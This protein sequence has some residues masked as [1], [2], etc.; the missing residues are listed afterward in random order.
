MLMSNNRRSLQD[1]H[2]GLGIGNGMLSAFQPPQ[3]HQVQMPPPHP[4]QIYANV[5]QQQ[6]QMVLHAYHQM[7]TEYRKSMSDLNEFST[8]GI[9]KSRS[10]IPL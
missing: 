1:L 4:Q 2:H 8:L 7:D 3:H 5:P 6:Q 9:R 10:I